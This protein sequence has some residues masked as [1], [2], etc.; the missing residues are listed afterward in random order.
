M[1]CPRCGSEQVK[2]SNTRQ[3]GNVTDRQRLC[4]SCRW[5]WHTLEIPAEIARKYMAREM[6]RPRL[7]AVK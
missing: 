3:H 1:I 4:L 5:S 2:V 6:D 7:E